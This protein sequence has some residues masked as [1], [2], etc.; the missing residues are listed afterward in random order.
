MIKK[1]IL[2]MDKEKI[3][4]AVTSFYHKT[5]FKLKKA[6]PEILVIAGVAGTLGAVVMACKATK[7]VDKVIQDAKNDVEKIHKTEKS[8]NDIK[9]Y[10]H[11]DAKKDLT[12]VY[13]QT[14]WK[15]VKL[16]GPAALIWT[17]SAGSIFASSRIMKE[18]NAALAA[19]YAVLDKGFRDYQSRVTERYGEE[20]EKEIRNNIKAKEFETSTTD[21]NGKEKKGKETLKAVDDKTKISPFAR[22]FDENNDNWQKNSDF[23]LMFLRSQQ[24]WANQKLRSYGHLFLNEIYDELGFDRTKE[25]NCVGWV[26]DA[27]GNEHGDN[28]VDFGLYDLCNQKAN[29]FVNGFERSVIL[30]FNVDGPILDL[31]ETHQFH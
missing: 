8:V 26:Y 25:G 11:E 7:K 3:V 16:Y 10:S 13:V 24:E 2:K 30:N 5:C 1:E 15:L 29:D 31:L 27:D 17:A 21:E 4:G 14:A 9:I 12:I 23:N 18:R 6:S 22:I 19:A 28:Y 20:I